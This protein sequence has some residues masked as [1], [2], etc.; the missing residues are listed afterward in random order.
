MK[1]CV[2]LSSL[3]RAIAIF[4]EEFINVELRN[5]GNGKKSKRIP[6]PNQGNRRERGITRRK[7]VGTGSFQSS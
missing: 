7:S 1:V 3:N 4:F 2:A 6:N 5:S